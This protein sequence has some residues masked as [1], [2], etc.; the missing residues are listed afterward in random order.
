MRFAWV[1]LVFHSGTTPDAARSRMEAEAAAW[2]ERYAVPVMV[3]ASDEKGDTVVVSDSLEH[4]NLI[5]WRHPDGYLEKHWKLLNDEELPADA[6]SHDYLLKVYNDVPYRTDKEVK[7]QAN[8]KWQQRRK[9]LR[10]GIGIIFGWAVVVPA[11]VAVLGWANPIIGLLVTL[12][13][14]GKAGRQGGLMLGWFKP[15]A[16]EKEKREKERRMRHYYYHCERNSKGFQ[17]VIAENFEKD[18]R[19][20]IESE[21]NELTRSSNGPPKS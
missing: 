5:A 4:N 6:L 20:R 21:A 9:E 11:A 13:A 17:R 2:T 12:Y 7:D 8:R 18:E 19:Q 3:F 1:R 16:M 15:S 10:I 14:L